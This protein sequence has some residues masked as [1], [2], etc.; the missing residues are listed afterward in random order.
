MLLGP[1]EGFFAVFDQLLYRCVMAF[2]ALIGAASLVLLH[3]YFFSEMKNF[4]S[5]RRKR[6]PKKKRRGAYI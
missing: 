2:L 1:A 6:P 3:L 5:A 4:I